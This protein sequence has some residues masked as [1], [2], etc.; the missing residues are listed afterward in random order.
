MSQTFVLNKNLCFWV[1]HLFLCQDFWCQIFL[2]S[3]F[4]FWNFSK[5]RQSHLRH[6]NF[7][8]KTTTTTRRGF[9]WKL[10][11]LLYF[12]LTFNFTSTPT[13]TLSFNLPSAYLNMLWD[14]NKMSYL[15]SLLLFQVY[16]PVL[17]QV[18][19]LYFILNFLNHMTLLYLTWLSV[20]VIMNF[21]VAL[22]NFIISY[23]TFRCFS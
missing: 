23:I 12:I 6:T 11:L 19:N 7:Y 4:C 16:L 13:L 15:L 17:I 8:S 22:F 1:K 10:I 3:N 2:F 20:W 14:N 18:K 21:T 9:I 5:T